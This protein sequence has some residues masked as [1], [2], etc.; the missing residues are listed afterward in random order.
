MCVCVKTAFGIKKT[1]K[2]LYSIKPN[3]IFI[4]DHTHKLPTNTNKIHPFDSLT[5]THTLGVPHTLNLEKT[6]KKNYMNTTS[7]T[8]LNM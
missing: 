7:G 5:H 4:C 3:S 8:L 6:R 2:C 1:C